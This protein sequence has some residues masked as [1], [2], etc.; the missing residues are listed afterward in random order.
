MLVICDTSS[1]DNQLDELDQDR[2]TDHTLMDSAELKF[3]T[4]KNPVIKTIYS[5]PSVI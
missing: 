1:E 4:K 5:S 3:N 2:L